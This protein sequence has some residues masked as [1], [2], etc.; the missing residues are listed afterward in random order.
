MYIKQGVSVGN[1]LLD[2]HN[3]RI[4]KQTSQ[5]ATRDAIIAEQGTK[6]VKLANDIIEHG[7]NPFDLPMIVDAE[8]GQGNF[9]VVEGN[10]RLT[11]INL[12]LDPE[13]AKDTPIHT[14][15]VK[16]NKNYNDAIPKV[17]DCVIAPNKQSALIW[18][19]RKHAN[20][21]EGAGTEHWSSM[22]KARADAEQGISRPGLDIV[23]FVLAQNDLEKTIRQHLEGAKFNMTT[24]DRLVA[25]R[26]LQDAAGFTIQAGKPTSETNE[27]WLKSFLTDL[28]TTIALSQRKG[29]KFTERDVDAPDK[30]ER[31]IAEIVKDHPKKSASSKEWHIS[32]TPKPTSAASKPAVRTNSTKSTVS[33]EEQPNLIPK[34]FKLELP[35]GKINDIFIELKKLDV[36]AYR[37]SVSVLMRVFIE[38]TIQYHIDFHEITLPTHKGGQEIDKFSTRLERALQHIKSNKLLDKSIT[39][40]VD[41]ALS[42][43]NSLLAPDTLNAYVHSV[44]MNPDPLQLKL[45]WANIQPFVEFIWAQKK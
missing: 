32:G 8:D 20:G 22:A 21:L 34:K 28:V 11:A 39:K 14:A 35:S 2:L 36:V 40:P 12:L 4:I 3:Y 30:R 13:L 42:D 33:T 6:L 45:T 19:N 43:K 18:I 24:L 10:R 44:W 38:L 41:V 1:L 25:T 29:Q 23:N 15:F 17:V 7:L 5:K 31:F 27:N 37:H 26:E 16:L 9:T